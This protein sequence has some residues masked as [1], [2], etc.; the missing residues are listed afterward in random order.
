MM[1]TCWTR[2]QLRKEVVN[3]KQQEE[4]D[5]VNYRLPDPARQAGRQKLG[6][7]QAR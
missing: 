4:E 3:G 1:K 2:E 7:S 5:K 6:T